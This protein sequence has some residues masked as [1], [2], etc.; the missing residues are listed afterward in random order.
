MLRVAPG[1][2]Q[3]LDVPRPDPHPSSRP[4]FS[5]R[6]MEARE[7]VGP[8]CFIDLGKM[9]IGMGI[10]LNDLRLRSDGPLVKKGHREN[11]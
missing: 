3:E 8:I 7:R 4:R 1:T 10:S 11:N 2:E 9:R 5:G 6:V